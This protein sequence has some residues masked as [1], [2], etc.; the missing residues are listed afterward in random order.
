MSIAIIGA[1]EE[2]VAPIRSQ[3]ADVRVLQV[4]GATYWSGRWDGREVVLVRSGIGKVNAAMT[5]A[6][7]LERFRVEL[8]INT[9]AAGGLD[10]ELA[11]GDVVMATEQV[12]S[13]V[14][15]TVF[16]YAYGQVPQ[17]PQRYPVH[18]DG[19]ALAQKLIDLKARQE[20]IVTGLITTEDSFIGRTELA[21]AIRK[22]FPD[23][24]ATDMEGAAI[25]Q[26][27]YQFG[28]PYA[29]FRSISDV[30]GSEAAGLFNSN[31]ELAAANSAA[32]VRDFLSLYTI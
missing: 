24:K 13:D 21:E 29:A 32:A 22:N 6:V 15:A 9:G 20:K 10:P 30:C 27:A 7:L 4:A 28:I 11:V 12:Y 1:M 14:D 17:M 19:L 18:P 3:L 25:A 16:N 8:I 23:S 2:E 31:L 26:T 5:T